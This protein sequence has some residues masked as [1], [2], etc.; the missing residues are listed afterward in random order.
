[1]PNKENQA[2]FDWMESMGKSSYD[3]T[4]M[5]HL[6]K[7]FVHTERQNKNKGKK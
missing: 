2:G 5:I 1:M 3:I 7:Q 4:H 6:Y